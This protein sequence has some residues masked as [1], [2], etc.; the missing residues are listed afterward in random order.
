MPNR[1]PTNGNLLLHIDQEKGLN[2]NTVL[3]MIEDSDQNLW[4]GLDN[5]ISIVNMNSPFRVFNDFKGFFYYKRTPLW[6]LLTSQWLCGNL[7]KP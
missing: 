7:L 5:G 4:L 1:P 3:S 2:N 6:K